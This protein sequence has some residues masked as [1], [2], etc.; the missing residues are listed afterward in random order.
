MGCIHLENLQNT[1]SLKAFP[2]EVG[3][4]GKMSQGEEAYSI[5]SSFFPEDA[6]A[7]I[8]HSK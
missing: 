2:D 3:W 4:I 7:P 8:S 5:L 1:P 6:L